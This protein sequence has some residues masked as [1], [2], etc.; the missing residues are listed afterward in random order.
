VARGQLSRRTRGADAE[1]GNAA[2]ELVILAPVVL[3]L[4]GLVIAAG[5]TSVAQGSV[6]AAARE[7]ARQASVAPNLAAA[8]LAAMSG[9]MTTLHGDGLQCSPVVQLNLAGFASQPG[10]PGSV[11]VTVQCTVGLSDLTLPGVPGSRTLRAR[12]ASPIDPYRSRSL[13]IGSPVGTVNSGPGT[14]RIT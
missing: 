7:A 9:A 6:D 14:G 1:G 2:L 11:V 10:Q 5:R 8:Q 12:F 3:F 13:S 4:V